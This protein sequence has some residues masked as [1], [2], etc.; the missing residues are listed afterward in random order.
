ML[1]LK[2][3]EH[4]WHEHKGIH[5][6]R[7]PF[8]G[9]WCRYLL[10]AKLKDGETVFPLTYAYV[11]SSQCDISLFGLWSFLVMRVLCICIFFRL[12]VQSRI[13]GICTLLQK[14]FCYKEVA[15]RLVKL[16]RLGMSTLTMNKLFCFYHWFKNDY[17]FW[18]LHTFEFAL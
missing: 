10:P 16:K 2:R 7:E 14:T 13:Y 15:S 8:H 18:L 5:E 3:W 9:V 12:L 11:A 1:D 4:K 6:R 17:L